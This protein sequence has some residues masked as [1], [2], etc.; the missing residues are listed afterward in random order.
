MNLFVPALAPGFTTE[1]QSGEAGRSL[2]AKKA[3]RFKFPK[4]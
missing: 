4:H 2:Q 3:A 1:S